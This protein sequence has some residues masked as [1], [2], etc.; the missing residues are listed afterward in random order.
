MPEIGL[1]FAELMIDKRQNH[2]GKQGGHFRQEYR[3]VEIPHRP[4]KNK[5]CP[6]DQVAGQCEPEERHDAP[7]D[8]RQRLR[9]DGE[10]QNPQV[11]KHNTAHDHG[12]TENMHR[13]DDRRKS[14]NIL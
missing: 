1:A 13:L 2:D 8:L 9:R 4:G 14:R 12:D 3:V 11:E 5:K 6:G 7:G 10:L